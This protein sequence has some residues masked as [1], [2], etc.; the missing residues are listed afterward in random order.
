[1]DNKIAAILRFSLIVLIGLLLSV[2]SQATHI[3]GGEMTY[4]CLGADPDS[5]GNNLFE[6]KLTVFRDCWNGIPWF[7]NVADIA[8]YD[9]DSNLVRGLLIPLDRTIN[10]TIDANL[11]D[12]CLVVPPNVCVNTTTYTDTISLGFLIGGYRLAYQRCC[13]NFT[14]LNII[15]PLATGA[16][17]DVTI[18]DLALSE[19]NSSAKFIDWPPIY[20]CSNEPIDFDHSAIDPDGDSIVYKLCTP[21]NGGDT[22]TL[23]AMPPFNMQTTPQPVTWVSPPYGVSNMLNTLPTPDDHRLTIDPQTGFLTGIPNTTGQFVV[24]ICIEEYRDGF[25]ISETRRDFQYNVGICGE[26]ISS[27]FLP[28]ISCDGLT[29]DFDNE[30]LN[31]DEYL[32]IFNDPDNPG[33][34]STLPNPSYTYSDTGTY[35]ITLIAEPGN[36]CV[37][38]FTQTVNL[39]LP[40]L[41]ADFEILPD[42]CANSYTVSVIDVSADTISNI[43]AWFWTFSNATGVI[44]SSRLQNPSFT[45]TDHLVQHTIEL[46][47]RSANGCEQRVIRS[48][49]ARFITAE[50]ISDSIAICGQDSVRLLTNL[51]PSYNYEWSPAE[52]L[53]DTASFNPLAFPSETTTYTVYIYD[54]IRFCELIYDITV[55]IPDSIEIDMPPDTTICEQE[56]ALTAFSAQAAQYSWTLDSLTGQEIAT[57]ATAQVAFEGQERFYLTVEDRFGCQAIDSVLL[58]ENSVNVALE[59]SLIL[60]PGEPIR[61]QAVNLDPED[62]LMYS[63]TPLA[64]IL[65]GATTDTPLVSFNAPGTY[66]LSLLS[67][68]QFD[69]DVVDSLTI[70]VL[71]TSAQ[72]A[73]VS[74]SQCGGFTV[75][76]SNNSVNAPFYQWNFGDPSNPTAGSSLL[77]PSYTYPDTGTYLVTLTFSID[78]DCP[79]T[80]VKTIRVVE[81]LINADFDWEVVECGDSLVV[82]FT[83]QSTNDQ[84]TIQGWEWTFSNGASASQPDTTLTFLESESLMATLIIQSDDGCSDTL[85]QQIP[86]ELIEIDLPDSVAICPGGSVELNP[87]PDTS[88]VYE[89][90]PATGLDD[91]TL[92]NPIASPLVP[93]IYSVTITDFSRDTCQIVKTIGTFFTR[94]LVIDLPESDTTCLNEFTIIANINQIVNVE[95]SLDS[96]FSPGTI[97]GM[98]TDLQVTPSDS[99]TYYIRATDQNGCVTRDE[100]KVFGR[101][102]RAVPSTYGICLGDT[103]ELQIEELNPLDTYTFSWRPEEEIIEGADTENP[104]V[105]PSETTVFSADITNQYGCSARINSLVEVLPAS[106]ALSIIPTLDT[107]IM[108]DSI[109]L[110]A[111]EDSSYTYSW[112]PTESLSDSSIFNPI[113]SPSETTTYSLTVSNRLGCQNTAT[114]TIV[115]ISSICDD[116]YIFIPNAFSPNG[117]GENETFRVLGFNIDEIYLVVYNR[118]GQKI[119]ETESTD[120]GWDGTYQ[121]KALPPDVFGYYVRL[122]CITGEEFFRKGNVT[123]LR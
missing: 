22:T 108:G 40:S 67:E 96:L 66:Q 55:V 20:I 19:C 43:V 91:P 26:A 21:I 32:W 57:E 4:T 10:D 92:P 5:V 80:I 14:I 76:F 122:R 11:S 23:G 29:I 31:A 83:D 116:P 74:S 79:D 36:E 13:R 3:V 84:G 41:S 8:V 49:P 51:A 63:W 102:V 46:V 35:T 2:P 59:D 27:F 123:L 15:A 111:T 9:R 118:W 1:M 75:Q 77:N 56:F 28:E 94:E 90:S 78:V 34:T 60:C 117:D 42:T 50:P 97:I 39:Q 119:F 109:M 65:E 53:S 69:C 93:T 71:D 112:T 81:P 16:T 87:N 64:N 120:Q 86:I 48:F 61:L 82:A 115:V 107:I 73:F 58:M 106:P 70:T 52:G 24:G 103:I 37:D 113:A 104:L 121:G 25:L 17:F 72:A 6:I 38:T 105:S 101:G 30:S 47:V 88:Y 95:W 85:S 68:N 98:G 54:N 45:A 99:T 110:M 89:W 44:D 62:T 7:D 12:P 114:V 18:S 100:I 33:A